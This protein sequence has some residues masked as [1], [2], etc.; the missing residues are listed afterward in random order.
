MNRL[1][2]AVI[3]F[4]DHLYGIPGD[5]APAARR[6]PALTITKT[7]PERIGLEDDVSS[8][9][10]GLALGPGPVAQVQQPLFKIRP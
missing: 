9:A 6:L 1:R 3:L 10:A 4:E 2:S 7:G 5:D 8:L